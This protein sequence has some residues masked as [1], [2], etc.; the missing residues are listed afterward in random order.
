MIEITIEPELWKIA[1]EHL[2]ARAE[3][4]GFFLADWEPRGRCFKVRAWRPIDEVAGDPNEMHVSLSDETRLS[5]IQWAGAEEA[6]LIEAHS[7]G[8][9][10]P[11]AFSPFDL[12]SL[13][14]WVPH[15]W[16]RLHGRPYAAIVTSSLDLDALAWIDDPRR[17]EQVDGVSA[18]SY[19]QAT[20]ATRLV[21]A[22]E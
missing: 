9:W 22:K 20:K 11:A 19:F 10:C 21:R 7:H 5:V 4:A 15:L 8:H 16:W 6:C 17:S 14:D 13:G 18:G 3:R 2:D 12:R 1:R